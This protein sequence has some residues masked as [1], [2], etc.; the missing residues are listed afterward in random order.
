M[1]TAIPTET[2]TLVL[3]QRKALK[4]AEESKAPIVIEVSSADYNYQWLN[5]VKEGIKSGPVLLVAQN[6]P[7]PGLLG[8]INCLRREPNFQNVRCFIIMDR[9]TPKFSLND[10][11]YASQLELGLAVNIYRNSVWGTYR[12]FQ[13]TQNLPETSR[14][15]H[16]YANVIKS[17][18]LCKS[19]QFNYNVELFK[20]LR[21]HRFSVSV[22]YHRSIGSTAV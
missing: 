9:L 5:S 16:C 20:M 1:I 8:L 2:E 22:I 10:N 11:L 19:F 6:D 15:D 13:L 3:L 14:L 17:L 7:T 18:N 4:S 12:F 21:S